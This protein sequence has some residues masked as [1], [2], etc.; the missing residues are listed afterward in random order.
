MGVG[1]VERE[2]KRVTIVLGKDR[3]MRTAERYFRYFRY[4]PRESNL[5]S[6]PREPAS[7]K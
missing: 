3:R 1:G 6:V 2:R 5:S 4:Y 7:Q